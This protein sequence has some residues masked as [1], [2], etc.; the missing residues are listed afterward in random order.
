MPTPP[1]AI[2]GSTRGSALEAIF[3]AVQAGQI[4]PDFRCVVSDVEHAGILEKAQSRK[5]PGYHIPR[6][7]RSRRQFEESVHQI[8]SHHQAEIILLIG[9]MRILSPRFVSLWKN[10]IV[11]L[12]P[13]LLPAH[14]GLMDLQ[15]HQSVLDAKESTT[16]CTLHLVTAEVDAGRPLIQKCC[17]VLESDDAASLKARVQRLEAQTLVQ[18]LVNP[19]QYL[20]F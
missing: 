9:F 6:A 14:A 4:A 5:I 3:E 11:N 8:I 17:P 20:E 1:L 15:V 19:L 18:F 2:L 12:H 13:S 16:G 7:G 10:R